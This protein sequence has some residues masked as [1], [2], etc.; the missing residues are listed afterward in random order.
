MKKENGNKTHCNHLTS[1]DSKLKFL[2]IKLLGG[3]LSRLMIKTFSVHKYLIQPHF[4]N[5]E[6]PFK[7]P[8]GLFS[9][10]DLDDLKSAAQTD[11]QIKLLIT[12]RKSQRELEGFH[13]HETDLFFHCRL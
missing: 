13:H 4:K 8:Q 3:F 6:L 12:Q 2:T 1:R 9:E 11:D 5:F 7:S 10:E